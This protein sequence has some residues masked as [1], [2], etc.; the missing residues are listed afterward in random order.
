MVEMTE[1]LGAAA[2][3][4]YEA[5]HPGYS[6]D[7]ADPDVRHRTLDAVRPA[8]VATLAAVEAAELEKAAPPPS[9]RA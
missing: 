5:R 8:V 3:A 2:R 6:W 9:A 4:T 7:A 1:A